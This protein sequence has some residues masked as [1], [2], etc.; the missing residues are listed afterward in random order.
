MEPAGSLP[1][2]Q[3][4][5]TCPHPEPD[6]SIPCPHPTTWRSI[7]IL[8]SHLLLGKGSPET[9]KFSFYI[10]AYAVKELYWNKLLSM[11]IGT[12]LR[13]NNF[14]IP[15]N[16]GRNKDPDAQ[17]FVS[18]KSLTVYF[19]V[20][21]IRGDKRK[22]AGGPMR[23]PEKRLPGLLPEVEKTLGAVYEQPMG[24]LR[25]RQNWV[26]CRWAQKNYIKKLRTLFEQ[27][28]YIAKPLIMAEL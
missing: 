28:S 27:T 11:G 16:V 1:H 5:T 3:E 22:I 8:S 26:A 14:R 10:I 25:R 13:I 17:N 23:D 15:T 21:N 2:P 6:Q 24:V 18:S 20:S 12:R 7:L 9:N 4:P 19:W